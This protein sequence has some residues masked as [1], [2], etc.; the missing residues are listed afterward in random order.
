MSALLSGCAT[1]PLNSCEQFDQ[2]RSH[3]RYDTVYR[4]SAAD[5][6]VASK[7]FVPARRSEPV[8]VRWYTLRVN[9]TQI[10]P[11][12]HLYLTKDLYLRRANDVSIMLNEQRE[13]YSAEGQLIATKR[14]DVTSQL[15][16]SGFYSASIPLPIPREAP[17]GAY[18]VVT[19]L[20]LKL[21]N[22][23]ERTIASASAEFRVH[24]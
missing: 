9:R 24:P 12:D 8:T 17:P 4:Y 22:A 15:D 21:P 7:S 10:R 3:M 13:F 2:A 1:E 20:L 5:T 11:C 23:A 18:R 6:R 16:T 19:R 14:E